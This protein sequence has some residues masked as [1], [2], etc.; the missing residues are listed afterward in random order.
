MKTFFSEVIPKKNLHDLRGRKYSHKKLPE[1]V[2]ASLGKFEQKSFASQKF[3]CSYTYVQNNLEVTY[4]EA[5][6]S[7]SEK[8]KTTCTVHTG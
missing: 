8:L 6:M 7:V 4:I 3:A 2:W 5:E 1:N